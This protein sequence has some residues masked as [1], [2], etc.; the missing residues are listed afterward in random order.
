MISRRSF[1][2]KYVRL[3]SSDVW[4]FPKYSY[5]DGFEILFVLPGSTYVEY[6]TRMKPLATM[7]PY[8]GV[9]F[10]FSSVLASFFLF[11]LHLTYY[12]LQNGVNKLKLCKFMVPN[13][14]KV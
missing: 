3:V 14:E 7:K 4:H 12:R 10:N 11:F 6:K 9:F 2:K 13:F 1:D 5:F 8:G